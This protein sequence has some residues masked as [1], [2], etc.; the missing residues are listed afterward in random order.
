MPKPTG[1]T[2]TRE[3]RLEKALRQVLNQLNPCERMRGTPNYACRWCYAFAPDPKRVKH[4]SD[5]AYSNASAALEDSYEGAGHPSESHFEAIY[6]KEVMLHSVTNY[7]LKQSRDALRGLLE[8]EDAR[9]QSGAFR[10]N[11]EALKRIEAARAALET[12]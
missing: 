4:S 11:E 10:P 9:I 5:C 1:D 7:E 2:P 3:Q 12:K 6:T 8:I